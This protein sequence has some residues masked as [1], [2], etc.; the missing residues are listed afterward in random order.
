MT[1]NTESS[2]PR[3]EGGD[4]KKDIAAAVYKRRQQQ[5][6]QAQAQAQQQQQGHQPLFD[7]SA[8]IATITATKNT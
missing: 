2:P 8:A 4:K 1:P 5:Q 6:A 7:A 3:G